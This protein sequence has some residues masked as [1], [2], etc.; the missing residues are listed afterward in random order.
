[1]GR[2]IASMFPMVKCS[3][4]AGVAVISGCFSK[5]SRR[6]LGRE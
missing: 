4:K 3:V 1:M 2:E 5:G 6:R